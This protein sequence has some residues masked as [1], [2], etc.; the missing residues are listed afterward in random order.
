[1]VVGN[2]GGFATYTLMSSVL[3]TISLGTLGFGAYTAVSSALSVIL[4]PV[5][6]VALGT[7]G[8]YALGKPELK[9]TIPL[10]AMIGMVRQRISH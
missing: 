6:W 9:K 1:M 7:A 2:L 10:V 4:G 3:S 8:V 5:G